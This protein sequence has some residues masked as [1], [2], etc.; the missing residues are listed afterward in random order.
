M[1]ARFPRPEGARNSGAD[2]VVFGICPVSAAQSARMGE[3]VMKKHIFVF[4]AAVCILFALLTFSACNDQGQQNRPLP[5]YFGYR[6]EP[7]GSM[8]ISSYDGEGGEVVVD[9][10]Y[11]GMKVTVI[12]EGAFKDCSTITSVVLPDT[13]TEIREEAFAGCFSLRSV[14]FGSGLR[15][16]GD[17]AFK[18]CS[19]L[20]SAALPDSLTTIG[21]EAF[22]NCFSLAEVTAGSALT[23]VAEGTFEGTQWLRR[24]PDGVIYVGSVAYGYEGAVP[25]SGVITIADGTAVINADAFENVPDAA[26]FSFPDS[27]INIKGRALDG[28]AWYAA[29]EYGPVFAG[30]VLYAFKKLPLPTDTAVTVPEGTTGIADG[31]FEQCNDRYYITSVLLPESLK[32]IGDNAFEGCSGLGYIIIPDGV[33]H[34]GAHAFQDCSDMRQAV[35]GKGLTYLP[36][37]AF[38]GCD[39]LTSVNLG[40]I[41]TIGENAL[42]SCGFVALDIPEGVE[43]VESYAFSGCSELSIVR[44]PASLGY[45]SSYAFSGCAALTSLSVAEGNPVYFSSGNCVIERETGTLEIGCTGSVIPSDGSVKAL[46]AYSFSGSGIKSIVIPDGIDISEPG[47]FRGCRLLTSAT[48]PEGAE[49]ISSQMFYGCFNLTSVYVPD[50]VK[51][52]GDT[53]FGGCDAL[54]TLPMGAGVERIENDAFSHC[55]GLTEIVIPESVR[56][57]EYDA[58]MDCDG[59]VDVD[60]PDSLLELGSTAFDDCAALVTETEGGVTYLDGWAVAAE[61]DLSAVTLREGTVGIASSLFSE[62]DGVHTLREVHLPESLRSIG[63]GAFNSCTLLKE[64]HL[65]ESLKSIGGGAFNGCTLLKEVVIPDA[66]KYIGSQA[67]FN[68]SAVITWGD[69]PQIERLG[70]WAFLGIANEVLV[71]P[72]SVTVMED[73]AVRDAYDLITVHIGKNVKKMLGHNFFMCNNLRTITYGG[74]IAEFNAIEKERG[75]NYSSVSEVQCTDG[76]VAV[77]S[78]G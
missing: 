1:C 59:L 24:H 37:F 54:T 30:N 64:V 34:I 12:D 9:D 61:D 5:D 58:F 52:I 8:A 46:A 77:E 48:L 21:A 11:Y 19:V 2:D 35:L 22:K 50:S 10:S 26:A 27:L 3:N 56:Y 68:S 40:G 25:E 75:W 53:A 51:T 65:P 29:K 60:L 71:I 32:Y 55:D 76:V 47:V 74:T 63:G 67:F 18:Q 16:I 7:D 13:V 49:I 33:T 39:L 62:Y 43:E 14:S 4:A 41:R 72:D 6:T 28:T 78:F 66:V 57:I 44:L 15:V 70:S 23:D 36:D 42:S 17:S 69:A 31:A 38:F 20:S 73:A 45:I